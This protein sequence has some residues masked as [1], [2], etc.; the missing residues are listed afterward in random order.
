MIIDE[1]ADLSADKLA[2]MD[3]KELNAVLMPFFNITRPELAPRPVQRQSSIDPIMTQGV[4][5]L[6]ELGFDMSYL[7]KKKRK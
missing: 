1:L 4:A 7:L 6:K 3:D 5:K 2:A